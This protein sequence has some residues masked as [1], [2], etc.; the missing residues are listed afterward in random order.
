MFLLNSLKN[1][2]IDAQNLSFCY[3][4]ERSCTLKILFQHKMAFFS[5]LFCIRKFLSQKGLKRNIL[6]HNTPSRTALFQKS[7]AVILNRTEIV[8][9]LW[10]GDYSEKCSSLPKYLIK[11]DSQMALKESHQITGKKQDVVASSD[12]MR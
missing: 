1:G 3:I 9:C 7:G 5:L 10:L 12:K 4:L 11:A 6:L 2:I 8:S